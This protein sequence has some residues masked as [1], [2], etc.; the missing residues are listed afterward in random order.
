VSVVVVGLN[1]RTVPLGLLERMTVSDALLPKALADLRSRDNLGEVVLLSTCMRTEVYAVADRFHGAVQDVRNFLSALSGAPP[2]DFTDHLYSF[3]ED[4][5]V[6]HLFKVASGL[7]SA[8]VGETEI[9]GQVRESWERAQAEGTA[10]AALGVVFR[11]AVEVG[12]RVRSETA[13]SRGTTSVSQAAVQLAD[14]TL[15]G[16]GLAGRTVLVLGAGDMGEGMA[17]A[18]AESVG[19]G[20]VLVANRTRAKAVAVARKVGG[21][22]VDFGSLADALAEADVLLTSTGSTSVLVDAGELAPVM[23]ARAG[24]PL[25][26]VDVAVP[27]DVDAGVRDLPG[28]TLLD[29][30]DLRAFA[31]AGMAERRREVAKVQAVIAE[32]VE[33]HAATASARELAPLVVALREKGEAVREAELA[34]FRAKLETLGPAEREAVE[35]L[36]KGIVAKLLHEPTVRVK[37]AAGSPRGDRLAEALRALFDI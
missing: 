9:L 25:L 18:L 35:A 21:H 8:V 3:Y 1:H 14:R 20:R 6:S 11:H 23:E 10:G 28:V 2:E 4:A 34:R 30:D 31:E 17:D 19:D 15:G 26:I 7:D 37:D 33:R 24:R 5:A 13:I 27:R 29:M 22:A 32:E 12:K 16:D 36:T